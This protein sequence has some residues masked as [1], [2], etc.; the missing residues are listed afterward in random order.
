[1]DEEKEVVREVNWAAF[2]LLAAIIG[3]VWLGIWSL[4]GHTG[5]PVVSPN[6]AQMSP[7]SNASA[8][9][10]QSPIRPAQVENWQVKPLDDYLDKLVSRR[11]SRFQVEQFASLGILSDIAG[12]LPP[13]SGVDFKSL[14]MTVTDYRMTTSEGIQKLKRENLGRYWI[15][16]DLFRMQVDRDYPREGSNDFM[17]FSHEYGPINVEAISSQKIP[18]FAYSSVLGQIIDFT[19]QR[20]STGKPVIVTVIRVIAFGSVSRCCGYPETIIIN[21]RPPRISDLETA[22]GSD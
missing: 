12:T 5:A 9:V 11:G 1:M 7:T 22:N 14:L 13:H 8:T 3:L 20:T 15:L 10:V 16:G 18:A 6:A 19:E 21:Q 17:L 4:N 2:G